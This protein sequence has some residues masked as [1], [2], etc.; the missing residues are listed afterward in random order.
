MMESFIEGGN[1][2]AAP[3]AQLVYGKSITDRCISWPDTAALLRTL[4]GAVAVRRRHEAGS[5]S[6]R[7]T[8]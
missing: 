4:A 2:P 6:E 5:P 3:L 7:A 1:Q 8:S